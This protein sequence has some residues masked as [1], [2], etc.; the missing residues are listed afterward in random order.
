MG[1]EAGQVHVRARGA[2]RSRHTEQHYS[3]FAEYVRAA[4]RLDPVVG[5]HLQLHIRDPV[6]Y[7]DGHVISF[8]R[9]LQ[10][11]ILNG[12]EPAAGRGS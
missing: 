8:C 3:A 5:D 7:R 12:P 10:R 9:V 4:D 6:A 11:T 2:E 1:D